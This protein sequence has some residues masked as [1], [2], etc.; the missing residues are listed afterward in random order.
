MAIALIPL[1]KTYGDAGG[2]F[3][4]VLKPVLRSTRPAP[5]SREKPLRFFDLGK[6]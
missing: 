3:S 6:L 5:A 4:A 1:Q 2:K